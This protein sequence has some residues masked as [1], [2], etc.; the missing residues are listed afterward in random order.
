MLHQEMRA[1]GT[2]IAKVDA[3]FGETSG[4]FSGGTFASLLGVIDAARADP[5]TRKVVGD[6]YALDPRPRQGGPDGGDVRGVRWEPRLRAWTAPFLM[7]AINTRIVRRSNAI[8]GYPYG[9]EFRYSESMSFP[10]TARGLAM[11]TG[12]TGGLAGFVVASQV[13]PLR[14]FIEQKLPGP[15]EG[16]SEEQRRRGHFTVRLFGEGGGVKLLAKVHDDRDPGYSSTAVML[17]ESALCLARDPVTHPGGVLTPAIAM[18]DALL[19]RLRAAGQAW[20]V[21]EAG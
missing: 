18:G 6:P 12:V 15:G 1:R 13:G 7:A 2:Q 5:E 21:E 17:S 14:R 19:A 9:E 16:P 8:S 10:G 11:A 4:A 3:F 20:E